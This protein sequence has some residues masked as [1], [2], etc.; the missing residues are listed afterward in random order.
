MEYK[1]I[2][3]II[4]LIRNVS[5][6]MIL[7]Y[8]LTRIPAFGDVL[9]RRFSGKNRV[10]LV[11]V[12]GL[13][14][15]YGTMTGIEIFGGVAN[16]RDLG[17]AVAGLLAG[18]VVGAAAGLIGGIYRYPLGGITALPCALAPILAGF[19]GGL[20]FLLKRG[21]KIRVW[22]ATLLMVVMEIT[23]IGM[24]LAIS[25]TGR[26]VVALV[27]A[28][29]LPMIAANGGGMAVFV[30]MLDNLARE[31]HN[32][33]AKYRI[34]SELRIAREIQM[35]MVPKPKPSRPGDPDGDIY[36]VMKPAKEVG[37]DLYNFFPIDA[38]RI[39]FVIGDVAGK[40]VPASLYMAITQKLIR[41]ETR[42]GEGNPAGLLFRLNNEL[43]DGNETLT[44]VTLFLGFFDRRTGKVVFSNAGHNPPYLVRP[45]GATM[46]EVLPAMAVGVQEE[47]PYENHSVQLQ[48]G[49]TLFLY[50]DGVTEAMDA[51]ENLYSDDRLQATLSRLHH[52]QPEAMCGEILADVGRFVGQNEQS[53]DITMLAVRFDGREPPGGGVTPMNPFSAKEGS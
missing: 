32:E 19:A 38:D 45:G 43:C 25:G 42:E 24:A 7:A 16:F 15:I 41:A 35:S 51:G 37:G 11:L 5:V 3:L 4:A 46:L 13:M 36:A 14:S 8:L 53:D 20:L 1:I 34:D 2:D 50:T 9:N 39:F 23:H 26:E 21:R 27:S 44:F 6:F 48:A 22:E 52:L 10:F 33:A 28:A 18:P 40:G 49:D 30:F 29:L 31:R 12:F 47:I 17:P